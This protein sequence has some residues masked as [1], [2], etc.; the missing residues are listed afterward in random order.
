LPISRKHVALQDPSYFNLQ[1]SQKT[2]E[3]GSL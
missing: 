1:K 2:Q 3:T